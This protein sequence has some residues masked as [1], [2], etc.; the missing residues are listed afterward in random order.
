MARLDSVLREW[1]RDKKLEKQYSDKTIDTDGEKLLNTRKA[2]DRRTALGRRG[3]SDRRAIDKSNLL[4]DTKRGLERFGGNKESYIQVLRSYAKNS[5]PLLERMKEVNR[6]NL[7]DY[8]IIVHGLKGSSWGICADALGN[9]AE[10]LERAAKEGNFEFVEANNPDLI[11]DAEK[12]I[13]VVDDTLAKMTADNSKP[14]RDKPDKEVLTKLLDACKVYNMDGVDAAM[15]EIES[16]D[17][18]SDDGLAAWLRE[19][20]EKMNF[21]KIIE[22]LVSL[23]M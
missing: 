3:G 21:L 4:L 16:F 14:Q 12:L 10:V 8:T 20:V 6:D 22:K 5:R 7:P 23:T 11:G 15:K 2:K 19:N 9:K 1:V 17:Y 18:Q 13:G